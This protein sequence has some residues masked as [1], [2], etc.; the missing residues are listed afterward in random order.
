VGRG[1]LLSSEDLV[2]PFLFSHMPVRQDDAELTGPLSLLSAFPGLSAILGQREPLRPGSW[3]LD[4][5][6]LGHPILALVIL[7]FYL[8]SQVATAVPRPLWLSHRL[9]CLR[10]CGQNLPLAT[11][12]HTERLE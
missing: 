6:G 8:L 5:G 3:K 4:C 1:F 9:L 7:S 2:K 10:I 12:G 11:F